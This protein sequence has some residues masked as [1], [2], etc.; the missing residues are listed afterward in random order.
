MRAFKN[1]LS[2]IL[3]LFIM[4]FCFE[5]LNITTKSIRHYEEML[6][7]DYNIIIV[8]KGVLNPNEIKEKIPFFD[9]LEPLNPG[10]I[11]ARLKDDISKKNLA[12]LKASLPKFYTLKLNKLLGIVELRNVKT[13]LLDFKRIQKVETFAKAHDKIYK[14]LRLIRLV[15]YFFLGTTIVLSFI[16]FLKQMKIWLYEHTDRLEIMCLFG[17]PFWFRAVMLYK[18]ILIDCVVAFLLALI[19]FS[20][21][22]DL[23]FIQNYLQDL[24]INLPQ[25]S[26]LHNLV[27]I[28]F[29]I[30]LICFLCVNAVMFKVRK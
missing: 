20:R 7:K 11:L 3:P 2:L 12:V 23:A 18:V 29:A 15:L 25:I 27:M 8:S 22:Y 13:K 4:M 6:S 21:F 16:L 5:I 1:H 14:L 10:A 17:A 26:Y 24:S 30:L 19:I 28:F 9:S